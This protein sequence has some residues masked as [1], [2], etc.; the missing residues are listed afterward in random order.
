MLRG[1]TALRFDA[2]VG[3][4]ALGGAQDKGESLRLLSAWLRPGSRLSL[5]E[6]VVR[7][8]QRLYDLVDLSLLDG[9]LRQRVVE[10][11]DGI[12]ANPEDALVNWDMADL[13]RALEEAGFG[14]VT[15][16]E[17]DQE[18]EALISPATLAHWFSTEAD[19]DR[20]TYAQRLLQRITEDELGQ[21][22]ALLESQLARQTVLWRTRVAFVSGSL[23]K[24]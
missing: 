23:L 10:T 4:N 11:E 1:E 24:G 18:A 15:T 20:S 14:D 21:V 7:H 22:R 12:Y 16:Q 2:I 8:A 19:R 6:T 13:R 17:E 3:R 9:D 5:A